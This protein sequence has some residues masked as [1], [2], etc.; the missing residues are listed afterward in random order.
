MAM[1]PPAVGTNF[2]HNVVDVELLVYSV[3]SMLEYVLKV[4]M[5][6]FREEDVVCICM[7]LVAGQ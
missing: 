7:I 1:L 4:Y 3:D 5:L 2:V 6:M